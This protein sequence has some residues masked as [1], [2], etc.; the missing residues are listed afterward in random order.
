MRPVAGHGHLWQGVDGTGLHA[1]AGELVHEPS[2][3]R[4]CCHLCGR[5]YVLLGAH[6]RV[7]GHTPDSYRALVG[8]CTTRALAAPE[9]SEAI[10]VRQ[11]RRA[12]RPE[13]RQLLEAGRAQATQVRP[14]TA[15]SPEPAERVRLRQAALAAGRARQRIDAERRLLVR[16]AALGH[17]DLSHYLR[18]A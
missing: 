6:V 16:L 2:S 17:D 12:E 11:A 8:L 5:W 14:A 18:T 9:L 13:V 7:H 3:G 1:P 4:V 15:S 10:R